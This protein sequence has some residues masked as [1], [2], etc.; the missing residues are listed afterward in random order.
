[1]IGVETMADLSGLIH[2]TY[3]RRKEKKYM[4][5]ESKN[6][7]T[8]ARIALHAPEKLYARNRGM[9]SMKAGDLHEFART[10]SK[11]LPKK[12]PLRGIGS[13]ARDY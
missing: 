7:A 9:L 10:K 13:L 2:D 4:P 12:K 1:M 3:P 6:Q 8:A 11:G 5:A